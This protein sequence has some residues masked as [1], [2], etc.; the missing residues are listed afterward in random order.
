[1]E[2]IKITSTLGIRRKEYHTLLVN[3]FLKLEFEHK[4]VYMHTEYIK[5][6]NTPDL[7]IHV[8]EVDFSPLYKRL[9]TSPKISKSFCL[10]NEVVLI[11]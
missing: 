5:Y 4:T 8:H 2:K 6:D 11:D 7:L 9:A 3:G 1:M 10:L